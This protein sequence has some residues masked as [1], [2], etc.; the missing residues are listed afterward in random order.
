MISMMEL[1]SSVMV[2]LLW[3]FDIE[4]CLI[5]VLICWSMMCLGCGC[6]GQVQGRHST[7]GKSDIQYNY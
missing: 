1:V 4:R 5:V 3:I 2:S 6:Q 7:G